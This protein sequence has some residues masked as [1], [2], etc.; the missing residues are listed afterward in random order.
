MDIQ[1][2]RYLV[3]PAGRDA[4]ASLAPGLPV[5]DPN[6]LAADLRRSFP[7]AEA[8]A[9]GEQLTLRVRAERNHG[10]PRDLLFTSEGL[11]MM[12][13]PVV[14]ARRAARLAALGLPVFD[15][16][17]GIGGDLLALVRAG[18]D[19]AGFDRDSV[20]ALLAAANTGTPVARADAAHPAIDP[21]QAAIL[22]D[23][24]RRVGDLRR[25]RPEAFS[26]PWDIVQ[27]LAEAAKAAVIKAPPGLNSAFV[28]PAAE[29]EAVQF[30]S[31]MRETTLWLGGDAIPA[32]RRA[33]FLPANVTLDSSEPEAAA[34]AR[35]AG[36]FLYDPESC[37]TRGTVVRHLAHRLGAW[38]LDPN[39]AYLSSQQPS[40]S[41]FAATFEVV[42]AVAFSVTR[43]RDR[44]RALRLRPEEI[45]RRAFPVEPAELR[46]LLGKLEGDPVVLLCTTL[47]SDRTIF[48]CRRLFAP[49]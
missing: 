20:H 6:R 35:P 14:A 12:T 23:P 39:I 15:L 7:P 21:A 40:F 1:R 10:G 28:P 46:R 41:P 48:I 31:S 26:P 17:A 4:L 27:S 2:A 37:V 25:F 30:A 44:L 24:S 22:L 33:V 19:A 45:R 36:P 13:H 8:S 5:S 11:E 16:T 18:A 43:L 38:L 49:P 42:D 32:L 9:L 3:S 29:L 47:A 34:D